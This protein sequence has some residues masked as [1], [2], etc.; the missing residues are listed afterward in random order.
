MTIK[1]NLNRVIRSMDSFSSR[2][3]MVAINA[4]IRASKLTNSE[5][6]AF[7]VLAREIQEMS[8]QSKDKLEEINELINEIAILSK[9][10]NKT[11]S[12]RMLLMRI[13]NAKILNN[14]ELQEKTTEGFDKNIDIIS[15]ASINSDYTLSQIENIKMQWIYFK[16]DIDSWTSEQALDEANEIIDVI[17]VLIREYEKYSGD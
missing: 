14:K 1:R 16:T 8:T 6:A 13:V 2:S 5:G 9:L 15:E 12:L 11:G 10:I 3:N 4:S 17:N 7:K